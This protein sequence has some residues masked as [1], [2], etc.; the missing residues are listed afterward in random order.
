MKLFF[1]QHPGMV[2]NEQGSLLVL[3]S[4]NAKEHLAVVILAACKGFSLL[5]PTTRGKRSKWVA[6]LC[7]QICTKH[8][9]DLCEAHR[10][11]QTLHALQ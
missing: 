1:T 6:D 9:S 8:L 3:Q 5:E 10:E 2:H 11:A 7:W 4:A